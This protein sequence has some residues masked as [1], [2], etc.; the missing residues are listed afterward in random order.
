[1][2]WVLFAFYGLFSAAT[3][4]ITKAWVTDLIDENFRGSAI[5]LL[6]SLT[7]FGIMAGSILAGFLW[8]QFGSQVPFL[9][10]AF[11]S[12]IIACVL[13]FFKPAKNITG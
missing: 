11:V 8:D 12:L 2:I 5:G 3:D 7:S 13:L 1:M 6:N 10:S 4:G 9:L